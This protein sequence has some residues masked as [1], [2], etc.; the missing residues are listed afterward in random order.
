MIADKVTKA[1]STSPTNSS[2]TNDY[3][4]EILKE[5]Y[6]STEEREKITDDLRLNDIMIVEYQKIIHTLVNHQ[7]FQVSHKLR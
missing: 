1:S 4:N 2:E 6:V 7:V 3:D 5:R